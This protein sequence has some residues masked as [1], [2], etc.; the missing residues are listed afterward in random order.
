MANDCFEKGQNSYEEGFAG[1]VGT[2]G[3]FFDDT[4]V[5]LR[6]LRRVLLC[7]S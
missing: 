5:L 2:A 1:V 4:V 6:I 3:Q 7:A